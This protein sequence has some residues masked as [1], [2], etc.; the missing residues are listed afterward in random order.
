MYMSVCVVPCR[1]VSYRVVPCRTVS[2]CALLCR[3]VSYCV[4]PCRTV[5]YRVVPCRTVSYRVVLCR[6]VSYCVVLC[7]TVLYCVVPCRTVSVLYDTLYDTVRRVV[8]PRRVGPRHL[9]RRP[10]ASYSAFP[11]A[12]TCTTP[13]PAPP[14]PPLLASFIVP[15]PTV[16]V[17]PGES[18]TEARRPA[19]ETWSGAQPG[20]RPPSQTHQRLFPAPVGPLVASVG[21]GFGLWGRAL[22]PRSAL[23]AHGAHRWCSWP[24]GTAE[25]EPRSTRRTHPWG[26]RPVRPCG[27]CD[28]GWVGPGA[29][30]CALCAPRPRRAALSR[31]I[32]RKGG[33]SF[34]SFCSRGMSRLCL[35]AVATTSYALLAVGL[36]GASRPPRVEGSNG[37]AKDQQRRPARNTTCVTSLQ[38]VHPFR[39]SSKACA[40]YRYLGT[41]KCCA[42]PA[43]VPTQGNYSQLI[44]GYPHRSSTIMCCCTW[45]ASVGGG[46]G[47]GGERCLVVN[48]HEV[49]RDPKPLVTPLGGFLAALPTPHLS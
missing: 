2:Y 12:L 40:P 45:R 27:P 20:M 32:M 43:W 46:V 42:V 4:V 22:R 48:R 39:V 18:A 26:A 1:T 38:Q 13:R 21:G 33:G 3:T 29:G 10:D 23:R 19:S 41:Y 44:V 35:N 49:F 5:S 30:A 16:R 17:P 34:L 7:C 31:S 36:S 8:H 11:T 25:G 14:P 47:W 6:T 15:Y 24:V 37:G 9:V 28:S